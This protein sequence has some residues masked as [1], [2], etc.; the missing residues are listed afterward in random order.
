VRAPIVEV[1][2]VLL[3]RVWLVA[4][5]CRR[6]VFAS[7]HRFC[8]SAVDATSQRADDKRRIAHTLHRL[9][10]SQPP[11]GPPRVKTP[12]PLLLSPQHKRPRP[13]QPSCQRT[14]KPPRLHKYKNTCY[15]SRRHKNAL[16]YNPRHGSSTKRPIRRNRIQLCA[17]HHSC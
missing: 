15:H 3:V 13:A 7:M 8:V 6:L 16:L 2:L 9:I 12:S 14:T 4:L 1:L 17:W 11:S 5:A 10:Q